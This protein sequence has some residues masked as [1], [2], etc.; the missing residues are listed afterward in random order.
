LD[1]ENTA[2]TYKGGIG[3]C[4]NLATCDNTDAAPRGVAV[5]DGGEMTLVV[6]PS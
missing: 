4:P 2:P 6:P 3:F 5:S 1:K